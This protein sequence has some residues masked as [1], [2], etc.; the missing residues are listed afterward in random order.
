[1]KRLLVIFLFCCGLVITTFLLFE[2]VEHWITAHVHSGQSKATYTLLSFSFMALDTLLPVPSS[3]LMILNGKI[4]GPFWG[5]L[6]SWAS[7][8]LA[9]WFGFYLGRSANPYFDKF[10]S[11]Q[12]KAYSNNLF[13]RFG[14][15]AIT[16]SKALPV[17]SEAISFVAGTTT[18][19]LKTFLLY[20]AIGHLVVSV[21]YA[22]L[23]SFSN[24]I[25]SGLV[26]VII[27]VFA[28]LLGYGTQLVLKRRHGQK[29][30]S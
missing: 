12:D 8:L 1:M 23:G 25:N 22:Y 14:N 19:P 2:E 5:T 27:I 4:L 29:E 21:G 13:R 28:V 18:M 11:A 30:L 24:A 10:F 26:T 6:L 7:S 3:L 20:S 16:I 15:L 17:L 9:S